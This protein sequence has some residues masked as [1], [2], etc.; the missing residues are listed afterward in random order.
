MN[1][2]NREN[3]TEEESEEE[4]D[5]DNGDIDDASFFEDAIANSGEVLQPK[6]QAI[7][8]KQKNPN[9][10]TM[11]TLR[12]KGYDIMRYTTKGGKSLE[13]TITD[14]E[15]WGIS[16]NLIENPPPGATWIVL[17]YTPPTTKRNSKTEGSGKSYAPGFSTPSDEEPNDKS[18]TKAK[19]SKKRASFKEDGAMK[20]AVGKTPYKSSKK[21]RGTKFEKRR[22]V[23]ILMLVDMVNPKDLFKEQ[24]RAR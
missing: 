1:Y 10:M 13:Y 15:E 4:K 18:L 5:D 24:V 6:P 9:K 8:S 11:L 20:K 21:A 14:P 12:A 23:T 7:L 3:D 22:K 2:L 16:K 17:R 19:S